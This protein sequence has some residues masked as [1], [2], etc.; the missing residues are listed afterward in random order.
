[1]GCNTLASWCI[2]RFICKWGIF[3]MPVYHDICGGSRFTHYT[4]NVA[5]NYKFIF[6]AERGNHTHRCMLEPIPLLQFEPLLPCNLA[7][8]HCDVRRGV[9]AQVMRVVDYAHFAP[10]NKFVSWSI[11]VWYNTLP[12]IIFDHALHTSSTKP[13]PCTSFSHNHNVHF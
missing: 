9:G 10:L 7:H 11:V 6:F 5:P 2:T 1:M 8:M 3:A 13:N 4:T 12:L